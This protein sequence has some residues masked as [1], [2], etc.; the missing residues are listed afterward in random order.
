MKL[1]IEWIYE[2]QTKLQIKYRSEA[3]PAAHAFLLI[4]DM[5]KTGRMKSYSLTDEHDSEWTMKEL[6]K[7][8]QE[9]EIEPHN[10][11]L[12]FDGGFNREE[13]LAGLGVVIYFEQ[14]NQHY[15]LRLNQ[16]AHYLISNNEAEY[17]ALLFAIEQLEELGVHHQ[18]IEVFGDSQVVINEMN[19]EW[20]VSDNALASWADKVDAKLQK[21][22]L[23]AIYQYV[24]RKQNDEA[25]QLANQALSGTEISAK[26]Q[27]KRK[28]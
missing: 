13:K 22:G 14:N 16:Q 3:I 25:D 23:T 18:A 5:K 15:R 4:E 8:L 27:V 2:T 1:T 17:A 9:L 6:K 28:K 10:V 20:A 26:Q 7:Y 12:Y 21:L 11:Q 24:E 19:G